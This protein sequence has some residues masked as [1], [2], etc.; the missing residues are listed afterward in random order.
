MARKGTEGTRRKERK[1]AR[2]REEERKSKGGGQERGI[3]QKVR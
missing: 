3:K 2:E 1:G